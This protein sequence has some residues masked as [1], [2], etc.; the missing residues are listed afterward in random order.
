MGPFSNFDDAVREVLEFLHGRLGL[1]LWMLSRTRGEDFTILDATDND[2]GVVPG[3][4][5]RWSSTYCC[6]MVQ[7][8]G[9]R[10]AP[11]SQEVEAYASAPI[12]GRLQIGAYVGVPVESEG[13]VLFGT[14]CAIDPEP[15][16]EA[17]RAELPTVEL[18]SRLLSTI[19]QHE[20]A[21]EA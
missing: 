13:G 6:R 8:L 21:A 14:I 16:P 12:G 10:I 19:L 7:G 18:L 2:Y 11:R 17:I 1:S 15:Q 3:D 4:V 5:F 9:P 20:R